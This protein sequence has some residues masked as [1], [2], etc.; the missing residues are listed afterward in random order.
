LKLRKFILK[1]LR[2]QRSPEQIS[3]D[4][5][6]LYPDHKT[7]NVSYE[8]MYTYLYMLLKGELLKELI[9]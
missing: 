9:G 3:N 1:T 7:M 4:L 8:T 2:H 5:K 6:K